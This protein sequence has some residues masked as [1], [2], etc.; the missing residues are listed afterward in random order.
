MRHIEA[1]SIFLFMLVAVGIFLA[2]AVHRYLKYRQVAE[3]VSRRFHGRLEAGTLFSFPRLRLQ[4]QKQPALLKFVEVGENTI[5]TQFSIAWPD[6]DLRCEIY[7][8]N[9]LAGLRKLL[10]V[11][12]IEIGSPQ[13]DTA[14]IISSNDPAAVRELL[15]PAVQACILRLAALE[16]GGF[17]FGVQRDIQVK[18]IGGL[19]TVTKPCWLSTYGSLE[20]FISLSAEL[21]I[22]AS[23][24]SP[25][26]IEFVGEMGE[27][28]QALSQCQVCGEPLASDLVYCAACQ[29]PHHR[30]CWEY[31]GGCSTNACGQKRCVERPSRRTRAS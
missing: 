4:F 5:H 17:A 10:G 3:R 27:P 19:M 29:T 1:I 22:A 15:T 20:Q 7:P 31:F 28:D 8:Q 2:L 14:Y 30:E 21:Y 18:W 16:P 23:A 6:R 12:D 24:P 9:M 13:F 25:A 11:E 26:G